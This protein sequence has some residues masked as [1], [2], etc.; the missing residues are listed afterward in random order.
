MNNKKL[1]LIFLFLC[2]KVISNPVILKP[3]EIVSDYELLSSEEDDILNDDDVNDID[4]FSYNEYIITEVIG[5][6]KEEK[7][8]K[9]IYLNLIIKIIN[10]NKNIL[11]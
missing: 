1:C 11:F 2:L 5:S 8:K 4:I 6:T 7:K 10:K 3:N 9:D